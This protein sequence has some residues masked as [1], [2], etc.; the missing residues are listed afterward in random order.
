MHSYTKAA[1]W[2][3]GAI[4]SFMAMAVAGRTVSAELDTFE[5]M[6]F[7]SLVG[8]VIMMIVISYVKRWRDISGQG[9]GLHV[10]RNVSHFV[11]QNLWFYAL[12]IMPLAQLFAFEFTTPI[13]VIL[14]SP[15][16]LGTKLRLP[17]LLAALIAF[18]GILIV[19]RPGA[20]PMGPGVWAAIGCAIGFAL[21][22]FFTQKLLKRQS[23]YAVLFH[24][25][26]MQTLLGLGMAGYDGDIAMPSMD[27]LLPLMV[28][29]ITGLSAHLCISMALTLAPASVCSPIDFV[30]LP[31]IA[32]VGAL[33]YE[34]PLD[35]MVLLGAVFIFGGNYLNIL[36][37]MKNSKII[38]SR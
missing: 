37:E 14:F 2:M 26:W 22:Y 24:M 25:T 23:V 3:S 10:A 4:I 6:T 19:A 29:S 15:L 11:G 33:F 21:P 12:T 16:M 9:F 35:L 17:G 38:T 36:S 8:A 13:W 5:I 34:E 32:V 31:A 18:V 30:R 28:V 7:R 1:A 27:I 20:E